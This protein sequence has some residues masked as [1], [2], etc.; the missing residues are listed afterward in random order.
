MVSFFFGN[1]NFKP[2]CTKMGAQEGCMV[3]WA[4]TFAS[5][6]KWRFWYQKEPFKAQNQQ[7]IVYL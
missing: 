1:T 3:V 7:Q 2:I 4:F 5:F 6:L